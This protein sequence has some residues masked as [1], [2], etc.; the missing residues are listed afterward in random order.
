MTNT[1]TDVLKA[2]VT[3]WETVASF[4]ATRRSDD[5]EVANVDV[6]IGSVTRYMTLQMGLYG[7]AF[8]VR[9][10]AEEEADLLNAEAEEECGEVFGDGAASVVE[11]VIWFVRTRD[12]GGGS[13]EADDTAYETRDEAAAA[14]E[15]LAA[16]LDES[17]SE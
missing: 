10:E 7:E 11:R 8:E 16:G 13:D 3:H 12:D 5:G 2:D 4:V 6:Q 14:A 1:T 15:A 9:E 17:D